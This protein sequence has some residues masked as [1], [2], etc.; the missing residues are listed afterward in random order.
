MGPVM[1]FIAISLG[2]AAGSPLVGLLV[3]KFDYAYAFALFSAI[4]IMVALFSPL[5]PR[6]LTQEGD[7]EGEEQTGLQAAYDYQ[8]QDEHGEPFRPETIDP[9]AGLGPLD[10]S[11]NERA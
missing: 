8:L 6:Y 1:P 9:T 5:Y 7:D 10:G 3:N 11:D 2:Q 4:G